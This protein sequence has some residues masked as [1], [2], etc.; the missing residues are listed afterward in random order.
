MNRATAQKA[1]ARRHMLRAPRKLPPL[2]EISEAERRQAED[3]EKIQARNRA[4]KMADYDALPKSVKEALARSPFDIR[5]RWRFGLSEKKVVEMIDSCRT[6]DDAIRATMHLEGGQ[7][8]R[9][10][11]RKW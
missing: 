6:L 9:A 8:G 11:Y 10:V 4:R 5:V 2:P 3:D 1:R 7:W